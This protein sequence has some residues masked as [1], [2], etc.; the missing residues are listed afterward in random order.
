MRRHR[1]SRK[2]AIERLEDD[3]PPA[4]PSVSGL[5]QFEAF[6]GSC[7]VEKCKGETACR[8]LS[9]TTYTCVCTHNFQPPTSDGGCPRR[10]VTQ[11]AV[12]QQKIP[13]QPPPKEPELVSVEGINQTTLPVKEHVLSGSII[14]LDNLVISGIACVI[15]VIFGLA[16]YYFRLRA[17]R[18]WG[19]ASPMN[20]KQSPLIPD[21]YAPNPQYSACCSTDVPVIRKETLKFL[22]ELGEGCFGKVYKGEL[23]VANDQKPDVVAI[24]VL[25]ESASKEAEEDFFREVEIM[26]TFKNSN[27]LSFIGVVLPE[28]NSCGTINPMMVF[29]YMEHGDLAEVL[30]AQRQLPS[31]DL[32]IP[33]L[34]AFDL[35]GIA[36][37]IALG[38]EYLAAQRFVHR[39]LACRNCLVA[40]GPT[41]KI[42]DFG[43]SRDVYTCDYYK[44]GGSRLMPVRWM[45]PESVV[46]GRFTLE[47]DVWSYGVVLWEIYSFGK[48]PY[49]G[50]SNEEV[51]K[52]I[53]DGI[54]L[55]PPDDSPP[56]ICELMRNCWKTE[57]KHRITFSHIREVLEEAFY[58]KSV[59]KNKSQPPATLR[60]TNESRRENSDV[61]PSNDLKMKSL[62][63]PPPLPKTIS[64]TDLLDSEGYLLPN[65]I[66]DPVQYLEIVPHYQ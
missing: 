28:G 58:S 59:I 65:E 64:H 9:S 43:M 24:K 18:R 27:I 16:I 40:D 19:D 31:A 53:V 4:S 57:P 29:E 45:S 7:G 62:P 13:V 52:L 49:Y 11:D 25:K 55:I 22:N 42:A 3:L 34:H 33:K 37:Q 47:S 44:I 41:V 61:K 23:T 46:Y 14:S 8:T 48:Q 30:R 17:K 36:L 10:I 20:L 50:H 2:R 1:G 60:V 15:I 56:L 66:K 51:L 38:M 12:V 6:N 63:R 35:L 26:S 5:S 32:T 54:M 21:R 39:D